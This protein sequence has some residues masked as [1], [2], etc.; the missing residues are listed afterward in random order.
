MNIDLSGQTLEIECPKC[1]GPVKFTLDQVGDT[2]VCPAC[3]AVIELEGEDAG[4][5]L[6]RLKE[7]GGTLRRR[8]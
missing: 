3:R 1:G 8:P 6:G 5:I 4:S 7:K 2:A